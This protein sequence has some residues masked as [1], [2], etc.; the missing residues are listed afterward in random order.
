AQAPSTNTITIRATDDGTP[1]LSASQAF[2]VFVR[3]PPVASITGPLSGNVSLTFPTIPG[4]TYRIEYKTNLNDTAWTTLL[5]QGTNQ[6][7]GSTRLTIPDAIGQNAQR[8]YR[9]VAGN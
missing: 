1:N 8:F 4:K 5:P 9:I 6:V 2:H 7:A 3:L